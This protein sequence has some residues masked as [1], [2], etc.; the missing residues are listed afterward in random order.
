MNW[1]DIFLGLILGL[2]VASGFNRGMVRIAVG[3]TSTILAI[4]LAIWFY[5]TAGSSLLPYVS[6]RS[7]ANLLGFFAVFGLVMLGGSLIGRLMGMVLKKVGLNWV[8]R[9]L[10]GA[11]GLLRGTLVSIVFV[12][13]V[14]AFAPGNPP[15]AIADSRLAPYVIEASDVLATVAPMDLKKH[16]RDSYESVQKVWKGTVEKVEEGNRE[17]AKKSKAKKD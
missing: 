14:T 16:F 9:F 12:M 1:L 11:F 2:S 17:A 10:G 4:I 6:S 13:A 15:R 7:I 3:L 8:D 5:G